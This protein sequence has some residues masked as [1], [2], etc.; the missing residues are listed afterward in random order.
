MEVPRALKLTGA[1]ICCH[2]FFLPVSAGSVV[3]LVYIGKL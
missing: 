3:S 1:V 2:S